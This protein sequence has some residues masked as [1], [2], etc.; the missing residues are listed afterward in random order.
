MVIHPWL[1]T[2]SIIPRFEYTGS[3]YADTEGKTT[4]PGYALFHVKLNTDIGEHFSVSVA[5]DNVFDTLCEIRRYSP[6]AGRSFS[7]TMEVRY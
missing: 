6:Q 5:V 4:L 2:L 3:R 7:I 1:R